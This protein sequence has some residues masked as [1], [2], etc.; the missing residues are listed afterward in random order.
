LLPLNF[1]K[2]KLPGSPHP[3]L[4]SSKRQTEGNQPACPAVGCS[5][6]T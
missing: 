3:P 4:I 2:Y 1:N 5:P 6:A